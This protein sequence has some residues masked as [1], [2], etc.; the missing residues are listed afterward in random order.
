MIYRL[1]LTTILLLS[2]TF[3]VWADQPKTLIFKGKNSSSYALPSLIFAGLGRP[4]FFELPLLLTR[5]NIPVVFD[6]LVLHP[7][8]NVAQ[9]FPDRSRADGN[10]YLIDFDLF[11]I[12]QLSFRKDSGEEKIATLHPAT[13]T[14][15]LR[16]ISRLGELLS[17]QFEVLPVIKYP[18]FHANEKKDI[19]TVIL[20]TMVAHAESPEK[21]LYLKCYDPDELQR[22]HNDLLP[23]LPVEVRLIQGV[24]IPQGRETMRLDRDSW[25]SYNYEWL[26]TRLG[27]RVAS[28]YAHGL[29]LVEPE[30][31]DGKTLQR[32]ITDSHG[33]KMK[34]YV[35]AV[36]IPPDTIEPFSERFLFDLHADGLA[37]STPSALHGVFTSKEPPLL[38]SEHGVM[39]QEPYDHTIPEDP[40]AL[41]RRLQKA[42]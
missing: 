26:F 25:E 10:F 1:L 22:V 7:K 16:A 11:E 38:P 24:D 3:P 42:L 23:G 9:L 18:W 40:E 20:N 6:D 29:S 14:D 21:T 39:G 37:Y 13:L 15:A 28:G 35:D 27:L 5:D 17:H 33:L 12:E 32:V 34:I 4:D 30:N 36:H 8:T 31:I 19:S 41:I 2:L